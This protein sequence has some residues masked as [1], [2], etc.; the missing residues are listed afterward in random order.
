LWRNAIVSSTLEIN[1]RGN[2]SLDKGNNRNSRIDVLQA[3][4]IAAGLYE[5]ERLKS[6]D[7]T[8]VGD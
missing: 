1:V 4:V 8:V 2:P 6:R 3:A 7:T 5:R